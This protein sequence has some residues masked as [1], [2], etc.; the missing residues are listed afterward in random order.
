[1]TAQTVTSPPRKRVRWPWVLLIIVVLLAALVVAAELVA[2]SV[3]PNTVRSLVIGELDLPADQQLDVEAK[4]VLLPQLLAGSLD[5]LRISSDEVTIEGVTGAAEVTATGVPLR[6]GALGSAQGTVVID[7]SQF[8][9]LLEGS[10]LP[11]TEVSLAEPDVTVR[12]G[13]PV[14]GREVPLA[15]TLTPGA[16]DGDLLLTPVSV[17][18]AGNQVDVQRLAALFG[19]AGEALA[20]PHRVCI[21]DQLPAGITITGLRV[22]GTSVVADVSVDGRIAVDESLLD[23]GTCPS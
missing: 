21:A 22:D 19:S 18:V 23:P 17:T 20:G 6:G 4:G 7:Q 12:G 5:E 2:R 8:A 1:M 9:A 16:E 13:I 14:L 15:L 11:I 3:V 10:E